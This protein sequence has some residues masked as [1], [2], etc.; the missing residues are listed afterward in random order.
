MMRILFLLAGLIFS[1][2]SIGHPSLP[3]DTIRIKEVVIQ[4]MKPG[5]LYAGYN[6][7]HIDS[8]ILKN[9]SHNT[10]SDLLSENSVI[11]IKSYGMGGI[12][13]PSIRGT[14]ANH[15]QLSWNDINLN[16][17]ML[18]QADL[19]LI[20]SG[21]IDDI[22]I[23]FGGASMAL[24]NGGIGGSINLENK[25][26]WKNTKMLDVNQCFGSFGQYS[27]LY[28]FKTGNTNFQASTKVYLQSSENDFRYLNTETGS[29]PVWETRK[30]NQVHQKGYLQELYYRNS[31]SEASLRIWYQSTDRNLPSNMLISQDNLTEWQH[32][33]SLRL[34]M[35]VNSYLRKTMNSFT[36]AW[37]MDKLNY[38]NIPAT[39][40]SRNLSQRII[41]KA[42]SEIPL[43][44][45]TKLK[46]NINNE[47]NFIKSVNYD[48]N[49]TRNTASF[50]VSAE[51]SGYGKLSSSLL[52]RETIDRTSILI[53]DFSAALKY[54]ILS[55]KEYFLKGSFS[56]NSKIPSMNDFFWIPGGNTS[57]KNE[58]AYSSEINLDMEQ[59]LST[60]INLK[61]NFSVFQNNINNMIQW[62]PCDYSYWIAEN[63]SKVKTNGFES[64]FVL[65]FTY[66]DFISKFNTYYS[67][68]KAIS[69]EKN[70]AG[71][72]D[73][74]QLIYTPLNKANSSISVDY[75][76]Y[77][78][79][80]TTEYSDIR[81]YTANN[82][83]Y[84]PAYIINNITSG[85]KLD[86]KRSSLDA[87]F[88]INNIF[89]VSYQTM[90]YYPLP[91]RSYCV[92][93]IL[94]IL[95]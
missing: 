24:G 87:N 75:G 92:K 90:A 67:H 13:S 88:S 8:Q 54:R 20:P 28:I 9:M 91:G 32:D 42:G 52:I 29:Y 18:G 48:K 61:F 23:L 15:T 3:Y 6:E 62:H 57:L 79:L 70:D 16:N 19:S 21:F 1:A 84:L 89:N 82:S 39:I 86:F 44:E 17:T 36:L 74:K 49:K 76:K 47:F 94:Q 14:G 7:I 81:F 68:T 65:S 41:S 4:R 71:I 26:D 60:G 5:Q 55:D 30:N 51:R 69:K 10:I 45:K 85:M 66:G 73:G 83:K 37:V 72:I 93:L 35:N 31:G 59:K 50:T 53:P 95:K 43:N 34:L 40:D 80:W 2:N 64:S 25:P 56:R 12:A 77:Y 38:K 63:I 33:E 58:Y 11:Y 78:A 22:N 27:G 46:I